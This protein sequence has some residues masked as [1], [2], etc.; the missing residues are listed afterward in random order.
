MISRG[1]STSKMQMQ[2]GLVDM[3]DRRCR[4]KGQEDR[5]KGKKCADT[6]AETLFAAM[7]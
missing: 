3:W 5:G 4:H 7:R 2:K 6:E 1:D